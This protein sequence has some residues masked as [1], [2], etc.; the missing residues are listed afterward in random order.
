[1]N[2]RDKSFHSHGNCGPD[3]PIERYLDGGENPGDDI[4]MNFF[5]PSFTEDRE[6]E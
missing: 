6:G 4:G 2:D 5:L 3:G 1:M